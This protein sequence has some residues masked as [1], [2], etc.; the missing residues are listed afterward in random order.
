MLNEAS[1]LNNMFNPQGKNEASNNTNMHALQDI[2]EVSLSYDIHNPVKPNSWDVKAYP[3]SVFGTI[4]FLDTDAKNI[5]T[6]LLCMLDFIKKEVPITSR[7]MTL[8]N[9]KVLDRLS[10]NSFLQFTNLDETLSKLM[11][12]VR[13]LDKKLLLNSLLRTLKSKIVKIT[14]MLNN[15]RANR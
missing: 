10:D 2:I 14:K 5:Y 4:E 3:I 11:R 9:L 6:S 1:T 13:H 12:I 8:L 7:L 15:C